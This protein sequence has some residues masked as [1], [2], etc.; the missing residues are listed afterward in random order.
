MDKK[1]K[2]KKV[3]IFLIILFGAGFVV[4]IKLILFKIR[5]NNSVWSE[6]GFSN[7]SEDHDIILKRTFTAYGVK[8]EYKLLINDEIVFRT[9]ETEPENLR[10]EERIRWDKDQK[11][12]VLELAGERVFG[13][14]TETD[15]ILSEQALKE[16]NYPSESELIF[17]WDFKNRMKKG[18]QK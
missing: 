14:Y 18:D 12:A 17:A 7:W 3:K 15:T 5:E 2:S 9:T 8:V 10:L 1:F 11:I 16:V 4:G 13:Y 6:M